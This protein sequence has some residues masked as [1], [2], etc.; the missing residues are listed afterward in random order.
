MR[1]LYTYDPLKILFFRSTGVY[2]SDV[3]YSFTAIVLLP[4]NSAMN[5]FLYT[6]MVDTAWVKLTPVLRRLRGGGAA[7]QAQDPDRRPTGEFI[8]GVCENAIVESSTIV[9]HYLREWIEL[10]GH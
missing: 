7:A 8:L 5:P 10:H 6:N 1:V 3:A 4:I 9:V 2:I